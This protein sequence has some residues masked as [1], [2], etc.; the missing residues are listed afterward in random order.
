MKKILLYGG[1]FNPPH[2]GHEFL[3]KS[4]IEAIKPDLTLVV[5]SS[6]SPHKHNAAVPF[7]D[8][9]VMAKTFL[10]CGENVRVSGIEKAGKHQKSYTLKT[11]RRLKK[12]YKDAK[13][14]I[15]IGSDMLTS[16]DEW[17]RYR[18]LLSEAV[19]VAASRDDLDDQRVDEAAKRLKREGGDIR[20]LRIKPIE[21]S[22]T[23]IRERIFRKQDV[24]GF[25]SDEVERYISK[26][27]LYEV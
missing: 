21:M 17:H 20:V 22:S 12:K 9:F 2:I 8:R 1:A 7:F 11:V 14:Y 13:I 5:P 26:R 16:F 19:I 27:N 4:A 6:V 10:K 24:K 25:L 3:L 23:E 15:L 18:R